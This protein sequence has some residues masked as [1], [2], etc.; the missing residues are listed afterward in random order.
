MKGEDALALDWKGP[1]GGWGGLRRQLPQ[2]Q[3]LKH[4]AP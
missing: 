1:E 2:D 4:S 3:Q